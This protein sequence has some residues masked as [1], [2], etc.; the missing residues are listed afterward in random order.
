MQNPSLFS[1]PSPADRLLEKLCTEGWQHLDGGNPQQAC[2]VFQRLAEE[3][4]PRAGEWPVGE[5]V[6][7]SVSQAVMGLSDCLSALGGDEDIR[8]GAFQALFLIYQA[9]AEHCCDGLLTEIPF[10]VVQH[11]RPAERLQLAGWTHQA[12]TAAQDG[13]LAEHYW[14][15]LLDLEVLDPAASKALFAECKAAGYTSL[16][17]EKLLDLDRVGEGLMMARKEL[18]STE[19]L[20]RF[21]NSPAA[22]NQARAVMILVEERLS[23][24]F[25]PDLADWLASRYAERGDL[26]RA[27]DVRLKLLQAAPGR[28]DYDVVRDLAKRLERWEELEPG[29]RQALEHSQR[30]EAQMELALGSG[31]M[32]LA[33]EYVLRAP[34]RYGEQVVAQ[35]AWHAWQAR[36]EAAVNLYRHLAEL[37]LARSGRSAYEK[38]A[39]Y[40]SSLRALHEDYG[41][42]Q[43][44]ATYLDSL[45]AGHPDPRLEE[46]LWQYLG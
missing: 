13:E 33:I 12:L 43:E 26:P 9:D 38:A 44:W 34:H 8:L 16:V 19:E 39:G 28:G 15:L 10:I 45:L 41:W 35:L 37:A 24:S 23:K 14:R 20:L 32:G 40:L 5:L 36:P 25:D 22:R 6:H 4:L 11:A 42:A 46:V 29:I 21:A 7:N 3:V 17:A 18:H 2:L 31:N 27:L 1:E 30:E